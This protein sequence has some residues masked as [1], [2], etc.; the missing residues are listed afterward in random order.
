MAATEVLREQ[1]L[2]RDYQ[3]GSGP[4][5]MPG[6]RSLVFVANRFGGASRALFSVNLDGTGLSQ[7]TP[8]GESA[9]APVISPDGRHIA[10]LRTTYE[11]APIP[12]SPIPSETDLYLMNAD[13]SGNVRLTMGNL[14]FVDNGMNMSPDGRYLAMTIGQ[15]L[16]TMSIDTGQLVERTDDPARVGLTPGWAD[17]GRTLL[18]SADA[19]DDSFNRNSPLWALDL[20]KGGPAVGLTPGGSIDASPSWHPPGGTVPQLPRLPFDVTPPT[21]TVLPG[22]MPRTSARSSSDSAGAAA[23]RTQIR[24]LVAD[25]T[26]IRRV[27]A[28]VGRE[29]GRGRCR[30]LL[31]RHL[32]APR[33]CS[34]PIYRRVKSGLAWSRWTHRLR[35]G[36]YIV[37]FR[38][39]DVRGNRT[40]HPK[41]RVIHLRG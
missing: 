8:D 34:R 19:D 25:R 26:G 23:S 12:S 36:I 28:A 22:V 4:Y 27:D 29:L 13:G 24:F 31:G 3:V 10:Y 7:L 20:V 37:R 38:S 21:A 1:N 2:G 35:A 39:T 11:S 6:G 5:W 30:F 9:D 40:R 17:F 18:Y 16:Y 33:S 41:P 14:Q 32:G 15:H